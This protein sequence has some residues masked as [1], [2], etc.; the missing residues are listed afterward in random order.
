[1][2]FVGFFGIMG[3]EESQGFIE[4]VDM[5]DTICLGYKDLENQD[6]Q[7]TVFVVEIGEEVETQDCVRE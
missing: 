1:M 7:E 6:Y 4:P 2:T 3:S 5:G